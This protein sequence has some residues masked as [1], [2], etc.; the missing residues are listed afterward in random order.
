M[1]ITRNSIT[2]PP[3]VS[4]EIIQ[5]TQEQSAVM[6]LARQIALPGRGATIQVITSDPEAAWVSEGDAKPASDPGLTTKLMTPYTLAVIAPFSKQFVRDAAALYDALI[7]RMPLALAYKFDQTCF[8]ALSKPGDNFDTFAD[9]T[10]VSLDDDAYGNLVAANYNIAKNGGAA[11]GYALSPLGK[12][13]LLSAVDKNDRPLFINSAAEGALPVILG[14]RVVESKGAYAS[15]TPSTVGVVGDWT[16]AMY[17]TVEGVDIS[18]SEEA[19]LKVGDSTINL[20]QN[21]MVAVRAEIELG[22]RADT[23]VFNLLTTTESSDKAAEAK[24]EA[25]EAKKK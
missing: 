18:I 19:T 1:P 24:A 5:K 10:A 9:C 20:W 21:N 17:G 25:A 3:D 4:A 23:S 14:S 12:G 2:L 8:G 16:Q 11:N 13:V 6:Q 22:F 7:G 15:G